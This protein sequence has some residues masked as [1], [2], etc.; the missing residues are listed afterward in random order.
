MAPVCP[1]CGGVLSDETS[2]QEIFDSFLALEFS[3]PAYGQVHMLTVA[4]FMIQHGRYSDIA[5]TWIEQQLRDYLDGKQTV[6]QMRHQTGRETSRD[7][8]TWNILRSPAEGKLPA[9]AWSLHIG[10]V[11]RHNQGAASYC[12]WI[13]KWARAI[14][15]EIGPLL[16][17][18]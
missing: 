8:R 3:D 12:A 17:K 10:D 4:C 1:E 5:L 15:A 6:E 14:L 11:A 7:T 9:I 18:N 13:R 16:S 2:C